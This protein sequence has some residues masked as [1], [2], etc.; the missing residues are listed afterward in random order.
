MMEVEELERTYQRMVTD[1]LTWISSKIS[2]LERPFQK[3]I[4]AVQREMSA[5]KFFR[6]IE[7]PP[8]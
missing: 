6:T 1:L 8:K 4:A 3:S 7:K 5:F 2:E